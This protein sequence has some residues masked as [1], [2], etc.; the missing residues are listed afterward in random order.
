MEAARGYTP[1]AAFAFGWHNVATGRQAGTMSNEHPHQGERAATDLVAE[2]EAQVLRLGQRLGAV[3]A[4]LEAGDLAV[5]GEVPAAV[6]ALDK[7]LGA[8]FSERAKRERKGGVAEGQLDLGAARAEI[9][10]RLDRLRAVAGAGGV[11]EQSE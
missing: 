3:I 7:A 5:A 2:A 8:V 4:R 10:R 1:A 6:S 11:S 9:R